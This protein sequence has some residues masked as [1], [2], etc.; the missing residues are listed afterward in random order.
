[1][2]ALETRLAATFAAIDAANAEDPRRVETTD[3]EMASK[4]FTRSA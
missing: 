2:S 4:S 3:G 1:M